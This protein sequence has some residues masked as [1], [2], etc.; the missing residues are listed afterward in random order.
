ERRGTPGEPAEVP[1]E[2]S[3]PEDES[4]SAL[5]QRVQLRFAVADWPGEELVLE[6][7][8]HENDALPLALGGHFL[9]RLARELLFRCRQIHA[10]DVR[11]N[12]GRTRVPA[13]AAN[14]EGWAPR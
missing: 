13:I 14:A 2:P 6:L 12:G 4:K 11:E 5:R 1:E 10:E 7:Q 3:D 9:Q 8:Q